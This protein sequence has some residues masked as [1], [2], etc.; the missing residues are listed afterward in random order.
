MPQASARAVQARLSGSPRRRIKP[1]QIILNLVFILICLCYILPLLMVVSI[2]LSDTETFNMAGFTLF[3]RNF[4]LASYQAI[5]RNPDQIVQAYKVTTAYSLMVTAGSLVVQSMCAYALSRR[6]FRLRQPLTF[7]FFFSTLFSGGMVPSYILNTSY[8]H[9]NDTIWI[10]VLPGLV[11]AWNIIFMRTNFQQLPDGLIEAATI[12]G[13]SELRICFTIV[14]PLSTP[15]LAVVGF[16]T[17][18]ANWNQWATTMMYIR[19][20]M[21]L[22]SLQFLLQRLLKEVEYAKAMAAEGIVADASELEIP[23]EGFRFA[24]AM[25]AMGPMVFIFPFFQ[26]YFTRGLTIGSVKG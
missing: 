8:L 6:E 23:T 18:I 19:R 2:S 24:M 20:N 4:S 3:P 17:F 13:A 12:D 10:Y 25:V 14:I 22:Y 7:L 1:G 5:F 9:L 26:K 16:N 15:V 11:S 21:E